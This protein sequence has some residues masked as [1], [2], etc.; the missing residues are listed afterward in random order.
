VLNRSADLSWL[1]AE[2]LPGDLAEINRVH[3]A[4][5]DAAARNQRLATGSPRR[6]LAATAIRWMTQRTQRSG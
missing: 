3:Q 4:W 2:T 5:L 6:G 1:G